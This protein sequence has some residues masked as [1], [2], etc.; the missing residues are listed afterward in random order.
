MLILSAALTLN[1]LADEPSVVEKPLDGGLTELCVMSDAGKV[2]ATYQVNLGTHHEPATSDA[3]LIRQWENYR[4]GGFFCFNDNQFVGGDHSQN[5]DPKVYAPSALDVAGWSL[6]MKKAGMKYAVLTTRHTSGFLLWDSAT[7]EFDVGSSPNR[8]DVVGEF[9]KQCRQHGIAP[10]FYYCLWGGKA[11]L[12]HP[13]ARAIILAQLHELASRYGEIPYFWIDMVNWRPDNLSPQ[14]IYDSIRN[15]QPHAVVILNQHIQDGSTINYFPTDVV[16]GEV[17]LPPAAGHQPFRKVNGKRYYL[18]FEFEPVSQRIPE[19][20]TT[21]WGPVG[22]WF[23]GRNSRPFPVKPLFDWIQQAYAR[24]ANNVLLSLAA[25]ETGSMRPDDVR[26]L[27][28]LGTMLREAGL[29]EVPEAAA[30]PAVSLAL[31]KPAAA[32]GVWENNVQQYGPA[33]AFDDDPSTRW[34]GPVGA[35]DGWLEVDL[36]KDAT[37]CRAVIREGWERTREFSL[38]YKVGNEWKA[39]A[40]GTTI[41]VCRELR[42]APV[43][44]QVFRLNITAATDVP[45]IWEFELFAP[46]K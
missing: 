24:G 33:R 45:T 12:P 16:N 14:E 3:G 42:F 18:P 4:F 37:V 8:T 28:E 31:G 40:A 21:P 35:R 9:A 41:G 30:P 6:A 13:N 46:E 25:D 19:G 39:A 27:E 36:G 5:K 22:A 2:V 26:Q 38:Q 1:G 11:W 29:L 10:G 23:T 43:T 44:A 17:H 20:T 32:S 34:G 7:S 15:Q